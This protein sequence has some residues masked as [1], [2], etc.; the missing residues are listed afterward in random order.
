MVPR[1]SLKEGTKLEGI[2]ELWFL[3][4]WFVE[5]IEDLRGLQ[6]LLTWL[7]VFKTFMKDLYKL[8]KDPWSLR[9]ICT[10]HH[11]AQE[12]TF[13]SLPLRLHSA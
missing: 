4:L 9:V 1:S 11:M 10:I 7:H 13:S 6:V 8:M 5:D 2:I 3:H 12:L